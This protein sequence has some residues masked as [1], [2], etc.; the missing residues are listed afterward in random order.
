MSKVTVTR[1]A[2]RL[3]LSLKSKLKLIK[4]EII[5]SINVYFCRIKIWNILGYDRG[6]EKENERITVP[7]SVGMIIDIK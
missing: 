6:G 7:A 1:L 3:I 2:F 4:K 5:F